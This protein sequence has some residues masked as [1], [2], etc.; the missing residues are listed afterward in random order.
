MNLADKTALITGAGHGIGRGCA[1]ELARAGADVVINDRPGS[2]DVATTADEIRALGR[3]CTV[4]E[5]DAFSRAGCESLVAE[6][7]R[8]VAHIDILISNP[9][10]G[11]RCDFLNYDPDDFERVIQATLLGGFHVSQRVAQHQVERGGGGKIVFISSVV[12]EMPL[13]HSIAY[14]AAKAGLNYM[15]QTMSVELS[16]HR[17]N[18]NVI[19]PGWIDTPG[20]H[21]AFDDDVIRAEGAKLPWGRLGTPQDIGRA[22]TFLASD[23]ADY[24]TGAVLPVDGGFRFKDCRA[25]DLIPTRD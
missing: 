11:V 3:N 21:A 14:G 6:A 9:A 10:Y 1:L 24:I 22:A 7:L 25:T 2:P 15:A 13:A 19:E 17:I 8:A 23:A 18:V 16:K 12:A 20:E 4:V 5:A